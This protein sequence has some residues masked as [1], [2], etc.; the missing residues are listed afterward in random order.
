[1][2]ADDEHDAVADAVAEVD[3]WIVGRGWVLDA[4]NSQDLVS[5]VYPPSAEEVG[6]DGIEPVTRIWITLKEG[7]DEV[8][9]EFGAALVGVG[10]ADRAGVY[11]LDPDT[12]ADDIVALEAYRPGLTR[13]QFG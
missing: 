3:E 9:L 1:M 12:L 7:D 13:P 4:E 2:A 5:W 8:V 6:D 11:L 10:G